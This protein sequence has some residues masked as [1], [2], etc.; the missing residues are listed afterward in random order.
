MLY[1]CSTHTA[2]HANN[3]HARLCSEELKNG[4][5]ASAD[6]GVFSQFSHSPFTLSAGDASTRA[7]DATVLSML[8]NE[9]RDGTLSASEDS[10]FATCKMAKMVEGDYYKKE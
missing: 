7:F 4:N 1:S 9:L 10:D 6:A 2:L 5:T 3:Q 8:E